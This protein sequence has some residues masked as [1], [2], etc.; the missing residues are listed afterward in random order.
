[1]YS[2]HRFTLNTDMQQTHDH[3][4]WFK[5][6][7]LF[8]TATLCRH[9]NATSTFLE[10][11]RR[12]LKWKWFPSSILSG[13]SWGTPFRWKWSDFLLPCSLLFTLS[14]SLSHPIWFLFLMCPCWI[15]L[16]NTMFY[17]ALRNSVGSYFWSTLAEYFLHWN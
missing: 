16:S 8:C 15:K 17:N 7:V 1:M 14:L 13:P 12:P 3:D 10:N 6:L 4:L 5:C 11:A 9:F 2:R